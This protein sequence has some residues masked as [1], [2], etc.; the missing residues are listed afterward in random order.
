MGEAR[1]IRPRQILFDRKALIV[2]GF[3]KGDG[4]RTTYN[5]KGTEEHPK[6][7]VVPFPD[8]TLNLLKEHIRDKGIAEGDFIFRGKQKPDKPIPE[9]YIY[10]NLR[11]MIEKA[12]I[13]KDGRRLIVHSFRYTY[14]THMWRELPAE[15]VMKLAGHVTVGM[16]EYYN[17]RIIDKSMSGLAGADTAV[18]K[19]VPP[20]E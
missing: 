16:T 14:V 15:T 2:D 7:R 4:R 10:D 12:G 13:K 20:M 3:V 6:L 8:V 11:R 1:G 9:Y 18:Q 5:K 19:I 17:K